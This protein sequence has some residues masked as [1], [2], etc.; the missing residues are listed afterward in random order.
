M[1][2]SLV[3]NSPR[4]AASLATTTAARPM[5]ETKPLVANTVITVAP[6]SSSK[7]SLVP[8]AN[9]PIVVPRQEVPAL[10]PPPAVKPIVQAM[11]VVELSPANQRRAALTS[12]APRLAKP[13]GGPGPTAMTVEPPGGARLP[14]PPRRMSVGPAFGVGAESEYEDYGAGPAPLP[15]PVPA[16]PPY[17]Q[18]ADTVAASV[19]APTWMWIAGG[20]LGIAVAGAVAYT[21]TKGRRR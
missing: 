19:S 3:R 9:A 18:A 2:G 13:Y 10:P 1:I 16:S 15:P 20:V 12:L 6:L 14:P 8:R 7:P 11:S 5:F 21:V 17:V 4:L